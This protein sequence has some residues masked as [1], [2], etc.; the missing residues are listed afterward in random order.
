VHYRLAGGRSWHRRRPGTALDLT[1]VVAGGLLGQS[2]SR[3]A[4]H[5]GNVTRFPD[6]DY[7]G[8]LA[9]QRTPEQEVLH[10]I[11][12]QPDAGFAIHDVGGHV[13]RL[14]A[15]RAELRALWRDRPTDSRPSA[16]PS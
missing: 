16:R 3:Y 10:A 15:E 12:Q 1:V 4:T 8:V 9:D 6:I 14:I 5:T 13:D 11:R 2:R 7:G